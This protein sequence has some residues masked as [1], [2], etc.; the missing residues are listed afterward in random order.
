V[1]VDG[2]PVEVALASGRSGV[3]F[4]TSSCQPCRAVWGS[5]SRD[6]ALFLVTPSPTTESRRQVARLAPPGVAVVMSSEAWHEYGV[7]R[8]PWLVVVE[9]G[10][11]VFD[12]PSPAEWPAIE[13]AVR[14]D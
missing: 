13:R 8:A 9:D 5:A 1:D 3:I 6:P 11:V 12:G 10:R 2:R 14:G 7:G 4:I